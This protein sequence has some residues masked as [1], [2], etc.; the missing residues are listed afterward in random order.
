MTDLVQA[1]VGQI[2][3]VMCELAQGHLGARVRMPDTYEV[4]ET[5]LIDDVYGISVALNM[6]AEELQATVIRKEQY[7][8]SRAA[9]K[10]F[11]SSLSASGFTYNVND[12][13]NAFLR[14]AYLDASSDIYLKAAR[15][16]FF[17]EITESYKTALQN[18]TAA[19][20]Q[21]GPG[22]QMVL[23]MQAG[24]KAQMSSEL[25]QALSAYMKKAKAANQ[26]LK[27]L[28][29]DKQALLEKLRRA[30][31]E[32]YSEAVALLAKKNNNKL[33]G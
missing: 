23:P 31:K 21:F 6:L 13:L 14:K 16:A 15:A 20:Q 8:A 28:L 18:L 9:F 5:E 27:K 4:H 24:L 10:N 3:D 12:L 19:G 25:Q 7:E 33:G 17:D 32:L 30:N 26:D 22:Q 11:L 2:L 29:S 1:R